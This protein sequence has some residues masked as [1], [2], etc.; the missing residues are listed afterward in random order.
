M[1]DTMTWKEDIRQDGKKT[2]PIGPIRWQYNEEGDMEMIAIG[3]ENGKPRRRVIAQL[4][5]QPGVTRL[6]LS[7]GRIDSQQLGAP[8]PGASTGSSTPSGNI[9]PTSNGSASKE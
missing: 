6:A 3:S 2:L 9:P 5:A 8:M 4:K 7:A 1:A